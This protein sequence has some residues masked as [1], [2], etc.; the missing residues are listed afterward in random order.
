V[1]VVSLVPST[2]ETLV[3][4]GVAPIACTRF[5]EQPG[6][7]TVGGTK[8]PDVGRIVELAPD[9]VVMNDEEN[10]IADYDALLAAGVTV[11]TMSPRTVADVGPAV[12]ALADAVSAP[13]P[14]QFA[15]ARWA[16]WIDGYRAAVRARQRAVTFVWRRPWMALGH[17]TYGS[18]VL[19]LLGFDN[20]ISADVTGGDDR[21]PQVGLDDVRSLAPDA[22]LLPSE[23]YV[24]TNAHAVDVSTEVPRTWVVLVDGRDLFWWGARTPEAVER[25]R[26]A[27]APG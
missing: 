6:I 20:A 9:L 15:G 25:L 21:Y 5:C 8:N 12:A 11:H 18:S 22:I 7:P 16:A 10:R 14:E 27:L 19:E 17:D 26:A 3:A 1:R 4:I 23:P 13:V 2:T 24:F